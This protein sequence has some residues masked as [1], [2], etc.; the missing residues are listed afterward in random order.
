MIL[1]K[2]KPTEDLPPVK[3]DKQTDIGGGEKKRAIP[4]N[5]RYKN[6]RDTTRKMR[7]RTLKKRE[8]T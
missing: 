5:H 1:T 2:N 3:R 4:I 6:S 8:K 7:T